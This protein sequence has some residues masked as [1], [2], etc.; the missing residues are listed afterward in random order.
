MHTATSRNMMNACSTT[1]TTTS[2]SSS[3]AGVK[4]GPAWW[5]LMLHLK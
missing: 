2:G 1:T 3:S 5:D 4:E